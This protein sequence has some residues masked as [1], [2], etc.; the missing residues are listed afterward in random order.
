MEIQKKI[1]LVVEDEDESRTLMAK[2]LGNS[3]YHVLQAENGLEALR[4]AEENMPDLIITDIIM[5]KMD[6]NQLL[7]KLRESHVFKEVPVIVTTVR[8]NM[9]DYFEIIGVHEFMAKPFKLETLVSVVDHVFAQ[10]GRHVVPSA[11]KRVL[12]AGCDGGCVDEMINLLTGQACHTD[13]VLSA[14]QIVSKAVMFLPNI[15]V[16]DVQAHAMKSD[17]VVRILRKMPQF[18]RI[19]VLLYSF[20]HMK[21]MKEDEIYQRKLAD[22]AL[23]NR[24]IDEGA[25]E[26]IGSFERS[27]FLESFSK[28][29][30]EAT[31]LI[32]DDDKGL[33][34]LLKKRLEKD[35]Y[36]V[37]A[38]SDGEE[39]LEFIPK[40]RPHLILLDVVMPGSSGFEILAALKKNDQTK[41]IPVIMLTVRSSDHEIQKGL[42]LG[43]NDYIIKPFHMELLLKRM[44]I[45][46]AFH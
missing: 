28:Y 12:V 37:W 23:A 7:K 5:P 21:D 27:T 8:G 45:Q 44:K 14:D 30:R 4:M 2:K 35:G 39:G 18:R 41:D 34:L 31:V 16:L 11:P 25:T 9:R 19:P 13:F 10:S 43:A 36:Q 33:T 40:V 26:Y 3:G 6:G 24:C 46:L 32:I 22:V 42:D 17:E 1:I 20:F 15:I 29:L 38:A